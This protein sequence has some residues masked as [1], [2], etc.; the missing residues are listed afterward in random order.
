MKLLFRKST[1]LDDW[2][3][4]ERAEHDG[5]LSSRITPDSDVEG[6][7]EEML[8]IAL[9]I[10]KRDLEVYKRCAVTVEGDNVY[11]FSPRNTNDV[12]EPV[13]LAEGDDLAT[14][15]E[16]FFKPQQSGGGS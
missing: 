11:F 16:D 12:V 5:M 10:R 4:I 1:V 6:T 3:L 13:S 7:K 2:Y 9:A 15:I 14:Q 8:G